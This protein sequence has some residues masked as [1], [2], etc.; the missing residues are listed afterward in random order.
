[1]SLVP[2]RSSEGPEEDR[3]SLRSS[4]KMS[5]NGSVRE[6][7]GLLRSFRRSFRKTP[8]KSL[9]SP[10]S[11]GSKVT[12]SKEEPAGEEESFLSPPSPSES[13]HLLD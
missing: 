1:M 13:Q 2:D 4:G 10:R 7:S 8:D 9:A 11:K 5:P 12:T 6:A 3:V